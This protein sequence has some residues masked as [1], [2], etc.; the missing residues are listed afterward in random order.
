[1]AGKMDLTEGNVK[2]GMI[3]NIYLQEQLMRER[4]QQ[5]RHEAEQ[6]RMLVGRPRHLVGRMARLLRGAQGTHA[7]AWVA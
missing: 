1:M 3:P 2:R 4:L 6:E 5:R 7:P